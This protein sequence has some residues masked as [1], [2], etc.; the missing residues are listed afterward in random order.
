MTFNIRNCS[1]CTNFSDDQFLCC[2]VCI[3]IYIYMCVCG[4]GGVWMCGGVCV[5]VWV[6]G[7][8]C[9]GVITV[10]LHLLAYLESRLYFFKDLFRRHFLGILQHLTLS[11]TGERMY[12]MYVEGKRRMLSNSYVDLYLLCFSKAFLFFAFSVPPYTPFLVQSIP[13]LLF[14]RKGKI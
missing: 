12:C 4:G 14:T 13:F 10:K 6:C 1:H 9:V 3:C 5:G 11:H 8:G 7:C 2:T